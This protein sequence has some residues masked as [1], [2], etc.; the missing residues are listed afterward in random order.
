MRTLRKQLVIE[1]IGWCGMAAVL[2][3]YGLVNLNLLPLHSVGNVVLNLTGAAGLLLVA[4]Y[5]RV[6]QLVVLNLVW[7][8]VALVALVKLFL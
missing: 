6:G 5:K 8:A 7:I 2:A 1:V 4:L 3:A